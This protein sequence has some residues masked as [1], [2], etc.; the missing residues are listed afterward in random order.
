MTKKS[1]IPF[2]AQFSP[3]Q[4]VLPELLDIIHRN[5]GDRD[6]IAEDIR[7]AFFATH[8]QDSA[9]PQVERLKIAGNT[10]IA[11]QAY[12]LLDSDTT[13]PTNLASE[14]LAA[15]RKS[16]DLLYERFAE[17]ILVNL[18]GLVLV[19]TLEAM[20]SAGDRISL[21]TIRK[22]LEQRGLYVPRGTV[23]ISSMRL[24]LAK[25]GIFDPS[26][27]SGPRIYHVDR[28]RLKQILGIGLD[29]IDK[30]A[31]LNKEQRAFLRALVRISETGPFAANSVA[32]LATTLYG[33][34]YNHKALPKTVLFPLQD[35]GYIVAEK[36]TRGRGAKSYEVRRTQKFS[37]EISEP[38]LSAAAEEAGLVPKELFELPL[39]K[40]LSDLDSSDTYVKGK[41]LELLAIYFTRLLDLEFKGWRLR[42]ADT[43]GAEV[44]VIV[45]GARFIFSRWQIQAKNTKTVR[46]DDVAKEVG[47]SLTFIYSNVVMLVTTGNFTSDACGYANHVMK[48]SNLNVILLNGSDLDL[49]S[50]NP[51]EIVTILNS[52]A[53]NAMRVKERVDYFKEQ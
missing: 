49:V 17:H 40:I 8:A 30:L 4:V 39:S 45:E 16:E 20:Q 50:Q 9:D 42:S 51:M 22:R 2:G 25:A 38:I 28:R 43:G 1:E 11:L 18:K 5:A 35:I 46:L 14:L 12:E 32:D 36:T 21:P 34:E 48:T 13:K 3:N 26:V 29:A 24:W 41:A 44:D 53:E 15:A 33:V 23:H 37:R 19:E 52:K 47:L 27:A 6:K 31:Q 10:V 7:D